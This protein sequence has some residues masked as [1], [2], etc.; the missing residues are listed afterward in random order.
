MSIWWWR[1]AQEIP[2]LLHAIIFLS[3]GHQALI[4]GN[5]EN[6][7]HATQKSSEAAVRHRGE[8]LHILNKILVDPVRAVTEANILTVAA[9]HSV[10][11]G[12]RVQADYFTL[13]GSITFANNYLGY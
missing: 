12:T 1:T 7:P 5:Q 11:V 3:A 2:A 9:H 4:E 8:S 10:E 13:Y 6:L